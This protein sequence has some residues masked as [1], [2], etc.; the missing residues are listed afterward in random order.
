MER[1]RREEMADVEQARRAEMEEEI[2]DARA[3]VVRGREREE[4]SAREIAALKCQVDTAKECERVRAGGVLETCERSGQ[5]MAMEEEEM[6][7]LEEEEE[8]A[9][10][11]K[12]LRGELELTR[13]IVEE[14]QEGAEQRRVVLEGALAEATVREKNVREQVQRV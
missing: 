6:V 14:L 1:E 7:V 5:T 2:E 12:R 4:A 10:E 11:I 9:R 8:K 13:R 3:T